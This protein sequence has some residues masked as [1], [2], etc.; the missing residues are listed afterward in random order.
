MDLYA[1]PDTQDHE[2]C[3]FSKVADSQRTVRHPA[4]NGTPAEKK[5]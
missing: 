2:I 3:L 4:E 1:P 5:R